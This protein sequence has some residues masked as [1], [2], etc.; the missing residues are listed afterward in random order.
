MFSF[1]TRYNGL[2]GVEIKDGA[3]SLWKKKNIIFEKV[4]LTRL[5]TSEVLE[6]ERERHSYKVYWF[7]IDGHDMLIISNYDKPYGIN[8][9]WHKQ[10]RKISKLDLKCSCP[11]PHVFYGRYR[12]WRPR[13]GSRVFLNSLLLLHCENSDIYLKVLCNDYCRSSVL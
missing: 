7:S 9:Q 13:A 10:H 2:E 1:S 5:F 12:K 11:R 3:C 4:R 8:T 6:K